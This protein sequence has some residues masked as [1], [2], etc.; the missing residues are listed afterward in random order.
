MG[1]ASRRGLVG[2]IITHPTALILCCVGRASRAS[3]ALVGTA[4]PVPG[5]EIDIEL[6]LSAIPRQ[7]R[8]HVQTGQVPRAQHLV[9]AGA[10]VERCFFPLP[11]PE[12][13]ND[14]RLPGAER[15]GC[16][17][18]PSKPTRRIRQPLNPWWA[19]PSRSTRSGRLVGSW[20]WRNACSSMHGSS[21][22]RP[23]YSG[24]ARRS[25]I[26]TIWRACCTPPRGVPQCIR[27]PACVST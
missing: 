9:P 6:N 13:D 4:A 14:H 8:P 12:D 27:K 2:T 1:N 5:R 20:I 18:D 16:L 23:G 15:A 17:Q 21:G 25:N 26:N 10:A 7:Q 22:V 19:Y 3:S 11:V 24:L